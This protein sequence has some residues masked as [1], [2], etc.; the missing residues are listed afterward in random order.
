MPRGDWFY[1]EAEARRGPVSKTELVG[2]LQTRLHGDTLV[3]QDGLVEW[4]RADRLPEFI[5]QVPPPLPDKHAARPIAGLLAPS[6]AVGTVLARI[7]HESAV[8]SAFD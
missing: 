2:L 6:V 1:I 8:G 7:I 5:D 4:S 3:W